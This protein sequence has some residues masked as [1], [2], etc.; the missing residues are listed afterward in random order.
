MSPPALRD[1][2]V[3]DHL[4]L[5]SLLEQALR[6]AESNEH[7]LSHV[8]WSA[9]TEK[10]VSHIEAEERFLI[11]QLDES[12]ARLARALHEEHRYLRSRSL[13]LTEAVQS[14]TVRPDEI[15]AFA[16]ELRAHASHEDRMLY[17]WADRNLPPS[18]HLALLTLLQLDPPEKP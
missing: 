8:L 1:W 18:A 10:L 12:A 15:H 11:P 2:F 14:G 9:F 16:D 6:E 13:G 4:R 3:A 17:A 7:G 5:E